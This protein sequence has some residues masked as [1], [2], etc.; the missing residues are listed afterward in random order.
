MYV[1]DYSI[2]SLNPLEQSNN[3]RTRQT[4]RSGT[5]R[6]HS[7]PTASY[8]VLSAHRYG[9]VNQPYPQALARRDYSW[10]PPLYAPVTSESAKS[11]ALERTTY[12]DRPRSLAL[13]HG[14]PSAY[15]RCGAQTYEFPKTWLQQNNPGGRDATGHSVSPAAEGRPWSF[16]L[17]SARG[18]KG[19][20]LLLSRR[21][22]RR[23]RRCCRS[24][25]HPRPRPPRLS[26]PG[27]SARRRRSRGRGS[28]CCSSSRASA[29]SAG[30][31]WR[32]R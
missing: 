11:A 14:P 5:I 20:L 6:C 18:G 30:A 10:T 7:S 3:T 24:R 15:R 12:K 27:C 21:N 19:P 13:G 9:Q 1:S 8:T 26:S 23:R 32:S 16:P 2:P 25:L 31:T 4:P 17:C 28:S 22:Q 29:G